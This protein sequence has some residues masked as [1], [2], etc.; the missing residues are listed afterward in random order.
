[1][2]F[3]LN[4]IFI[5]NIFALTVSAQAPPPPP[6]PPLIY[7]APGKSDFKEFISEEKNFQIVFPGAPK[8]T[9]QESENGT[10]TS[11]QVYREG[12]NSIVG[13]TE[14]KY[15]LEKN[16][17]RIY[18]I[19][20]AAFLKSPKTKIESEKDIQLNGLPGKEFNLLSDFQYQ[21]TRIFIV[22][23]RI[24]EIRNDVTN[25]HILTKYN[26]EKVDDFNNET[27][28]FFNSFKFLNKR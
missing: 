28:R 14:F 1:M 18:E 13:I 8:I 24:Y 22:G 17:E 16:R 25:W 27:E 23:E 3:V 9:K 21:R 15:D 2:K 7:K 4:F 12:S 5:L 26:K 20:K 19:M 6:P 11:Y 10:V